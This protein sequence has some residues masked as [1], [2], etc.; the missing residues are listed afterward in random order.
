MRKKDFIV[1]QEQNDLGK[2]ID[3]VNEEEGMEKQMQTVPQY[4]S[5]VD[6]WKHVLLSLLRGFMDIVLFAFGVLYTWIVPS[7]PGGK[8]G[9]GVGGCIGLVGF[10]AGTAGGEV[11]VVLGSTL[12]GL[13]GTGVYELDRKMKGRRQSN[14]VG[15]MREGLEA[16]EDD[17]NPDESTQPQGMDQCTTPDN[18]WNDLSMYIVLSRQWSVLKKC[19]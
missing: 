14:D 2:L 18:P 13:I 19:L 16:G 8:I 17:E 4:C 6:G 10:A 7:T 1:K 12:G 3:G 15:T 11:G 5:T 9:A